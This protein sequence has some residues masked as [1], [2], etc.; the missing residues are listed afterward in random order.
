MTPATLSFLQLAD[1][2]NRSETVHDWHLREA[3]G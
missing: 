2:L 3:G 1:L